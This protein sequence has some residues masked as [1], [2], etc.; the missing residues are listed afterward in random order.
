MVQRNIYC[1]LDLEALVLLELPERRVHKLQSQIES[2]AYNQCNQLSW[3]N[4]QLLGSGE[5]GI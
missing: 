2:A 4:Q 3:P 5:N 1:C